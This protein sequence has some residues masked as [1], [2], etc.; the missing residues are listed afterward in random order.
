[1]S[2]ID[3]IRKIALSENI[4]IF[5]FSETWFV[6]RIPE[7]SNFFWLMN[8]RPGKRKGG[9]V[10]FLI[11]NDLFNQVTLV[12]NKTDHEWMHI[13]I[14]LNNYIVDLVGVYAP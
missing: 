11:K 8:N 10:A 5:F 12:E 9:G 2:K 14:N 13:K 4:D 1:M 7:V 3:S 6:D